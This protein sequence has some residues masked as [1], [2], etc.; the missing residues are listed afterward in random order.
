MLP[1]PASAHK[2]AALSNLS[3]AYR[4][5]MFIADQVFPTVPVKKQSD[6]FFKFLRGD[7]FRNDAGLRGPGADARRGGYKLTADTYSCKEYA[8]AHPIPIELINNADIPLQPIATGIDFVTQ[9][10][11]LAK[12]K[13]VADLICT[14]AN[15][16]NMTEDAAGLWAATDSTNTFLTDILTRRETIRQ[17]IGL[18]PNTLIMDAKT[19]KALKESS[20]LLDRIKYTG[21]KGSPAEVTPQMLAMLAEVDRVLVGGAIYSSDEETLAGTEFT[22]VDLWE[23]NTGQGSA[24]LGYVSPRPAIEMPSAGYTFTWNNT[25]IP[26]EVIRKTGARSVRRWWESSPKQWVVE[27]S[28]C[29]DAKI[30]SAVSGFLWT[31]T[32]LT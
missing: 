25:N 1:T 19:F 10:I 17:S 16:P 29:F 4:N 13:V 30:C 3:I 27:A 12:E 15:W 23:T 24:W 28:E 8:F 6:Y 20:V 2:D 7:W 22:A 26:D 18:Y 11:L 32:Y 5:S 21:T 31:D 14:A 9:S